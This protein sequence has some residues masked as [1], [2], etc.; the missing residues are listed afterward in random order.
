MLD[1]NHIDFRLSTVLNDIISRASL[2]VYVFKSLKFFWK[3]YFPLLI[4]TL[5]LAIC[6]YFFSMSFQIELVKK[7]EK[8]LWWF[9]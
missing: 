3:E 5:N 6:H 2:K 4:Y 7:V 9:E 1:K 8:H